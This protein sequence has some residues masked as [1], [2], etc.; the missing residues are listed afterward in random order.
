MNDPRP[1]LFEDVASQF[2][3]MDQ[4]LNMSWMEKRNV[5]LEE[6]QALSQRIALVLR[7]YCALSPRDQIA[8]VASGVFTRQ[9]S[10]NEKRD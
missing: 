9:Q 3:R 7:G 4:P 1:E 6:L 8:F 10:T 5:S 2:E